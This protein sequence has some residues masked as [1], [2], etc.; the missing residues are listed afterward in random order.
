MKVTY[1]MKLLSWEKRDGKKEYIL[2]KKK[3]L[4]LGDIL[5]NK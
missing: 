2:K 3:G 5:K 4:H 1:K